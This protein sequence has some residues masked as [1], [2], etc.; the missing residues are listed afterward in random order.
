MVRSLK[1]SNNNFIG[2]DQRGPIQAAGLFSRNIM[3]CIGIL[4]SLLLH[5]IRWKAHFR[6]L[7]RQDDFH[8][9]IRIVGLPHRTPHKLLTLFLVAFNIEDPFK[10]DPLN[11]VHALILTITMGVSKNQT[12]RPQIP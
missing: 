4:K 9:E 3:K 1:K 7:Q 2:S 8:P 12:S 10:E 6:T 11:I 5:V